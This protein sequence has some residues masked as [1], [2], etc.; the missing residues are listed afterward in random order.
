[1]QF[2]FTVQIEHFK[3]IKHN[4]YAFL[5]DFSCREN[6]IGLGKTEIL[7]VFLWHLAS[8]SSTTFI[9]PGMLSKESAIFVNF[10]VQMLDESIGIFR[11]DC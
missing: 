8:M 5:K 11:M 7:A 3:Y 6:I 9:I 1:M 10:S 4:A 2:S